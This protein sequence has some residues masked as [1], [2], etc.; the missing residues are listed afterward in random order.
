MRHQSPQ[1]DRWRSKTNSP[2]PLAPSPNASTARSLLR[3]GTTARK[4]SPFSTI[5]S[6]IISRHQPIHL[7]SSAEIKILRQNDTQLSAELTLDIANQTHPSRAQT[8]PTPALAP[9]TPSSNK[10]PGARPNPPS[11]SSS[12]LDPVIEDGKQLTNCR[13]GTEEV[14]ES[15][16][17]KK[18][19]WELRSPTQLTQLATQS[20]P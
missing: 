12:S 8:Y 15:G 7:L 1:P 6:R 2:M 4:G 17:E 20:T 3:I 13:V 18:S 5:R 19:I 10:S 11:N 16:A 14:I 9:T